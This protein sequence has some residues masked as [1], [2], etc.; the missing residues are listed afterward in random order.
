[1]STLLDTNLLTRSSQPRHPMHQLA[2]DAVATI[3][4]TSM[5]LCLVPQNLYEYWVVA[6]R[7]LAQNGL[8]LTPREAE[9]EVTRFKSLFAVL[10]DTPAIF[11]AWEQ[12]VVQH[13]VRGKNAHD[14]GLVAAMTVHGV[15]GLLT[16]NKPDFARY[17]HIAVVSPQDV[18]DSSAMP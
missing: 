1:M 6:T 16:F 8:G 18:L 11:P 10:E 2:A 15:G 5:P 3:R 17:E 4:Q 14:A 7:P 9:K 13:Q 12:L